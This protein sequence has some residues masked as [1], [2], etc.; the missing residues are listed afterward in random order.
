MPKKAKSMTQAEAFEALRK[1]DDYVR[2]T[3]D[4]EV[5]KKAYDIGGTHY[6]NDV[7]GCAKDFLKRAEEGEFKDDSELTD[8]L[9]EYVNDAQTII[10][11]WW[12]RTVFLF[13]KDPDAYEE[14]MGEKP[15]TV[16][17]AAAAAF[18]K[19]ISEHPDTRKAFAIARGDDE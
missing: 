15:G 9:N 2:E 6:W 16:E 10:Y 13:A 19:D 1:V 5:V 11:T 18:L 14:E 17:T 7:R 3:D 12:A 4:E 8:A